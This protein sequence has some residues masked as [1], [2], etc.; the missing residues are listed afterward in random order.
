MSRM[1][2][3][4]L[5]DW[6]SCLNSIRQRMDFSHFEATA[7]GVEQE[8]ADL[9]LEVSADTDREIA[10]G[11]LW[12][13]VSLPQPGEASSQ[14]EQ[15]AA[16]L[17]R[18]QPDPVARV[19]GGTVAK[20]YRELWRDFA[21]AQRGLPA[22]VET[23]RAYAEGRCHLS[24]EPLD[25]LKDARNQLRTEPH[26][27]LK[28]VGEAGCMCLR[29]LEDVEDL[30]LHE[31]MRPPAGVMADWLDVVANV[32]GCIADNLEEYPLGEVELA[33]DQRRAPDDMRRIE[34]KKGKLARLGVVEPEIQTVL[35]PLFA[36]PQ[37][38][39]SVAERKV[40][41]DAGPR[42]VPGLIAIA[43]DPDS[44]LQSS[45]SEGEAAIRAVDL[46]GDMRAGEAIPALLEILKTTD[47]MMIIHDRALQALQ[48][49]M[50]DLA[51]PAAL[52]VFDRTTDTELKSEMAG[53]LAKGGRGKPGVFERLINFFREAKSEQELL[54]G[55]LADLGDPRALPDLHEAFRRADDWLKAGEVEAAIV[56]LGGE[57]SA[58]EK[59][60]SQ[61]LRPQPLFGLAPGRP[62]P[63]TQPAE[64]RPARATKI[65]RNDPCPCGSGKKYKK[66]CG[67]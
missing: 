20:A 37:Q 22:V 13:V 53:I 7:L 62:L 30:A 36:R 29:G 12:A 44:Q 49:Q 56:E 5:R 38:R 50:P 64:L 4:D 65:G 3:R 16:E 31:G 15:F 61:R 28:L 27:A 2:I 11:M 6:H 59:Q 66:C 40:I 23:F 32:V 33:R 9:G 14:L 1:R 57:L 18:L 24:R 43:S 67:R 51:F 35:L 17:A 26:L 21:Q 19:E 54:A 58:A 42:V 25:V 48:D 8:S 52:E 63:A 10:E 46:L 34:Y 55:C 60:K 47:W 39:L 41:I 45:I